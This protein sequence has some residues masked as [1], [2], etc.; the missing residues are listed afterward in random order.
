[1][2]C[3][4]PPNVDE[5]VESVEPMVTVSACTQKL[6][7]FVTH[8]KNSG[9]DFKARRRGVSFAPDVNVKKDVS[10]KKNRVHSRNSNN[11][12]FKRRK[13]DELQFAASRVKMDLEKGGLSFPAL[14]L[15][16]RHY[17]DRDCCDISTES[18]QLLSSKSVG[19]SPFLW[20]TETLMK[21]WSSQATMD[22]LENLF[23]VTYDSYST[24]NNMTSGSVTDST[25]KL[26]K[27]TALSLFKQYETE[28]RTPEIDAVYANPISIRDAFEVP[29]E[30][31]YVVSIIQS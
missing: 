25:T 8:S 30:A 21:D 20:A 15:S 10:T 17:L 24:A 23:S 6:S 28:A 22:D 16:L 14:D 13:V 26:S 2:A 4:T 11:G 3:V 7:K 31:R 29:N 9:K 27:D 1:M 12:C 5:S 19:D 18:I